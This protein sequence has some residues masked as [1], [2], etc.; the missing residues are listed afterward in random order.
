MSLYD[1][2]C[3]PILRTRAAD[4]FQPGNG[5]LLFVGYPTPVYYKRHLDRESRLRGSRSRSQEYSTW[6]PQGSAECGE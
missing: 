2:T 6:K 5:F 1:S 4:A 3:L